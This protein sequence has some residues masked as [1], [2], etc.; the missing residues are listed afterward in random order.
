MGS[1]GDTGL[2]TVPQCLC[3]HAL[4]KFLDELVTLRNKFPVERALMSKADVSDAFRNVRV[5]PDQADNFCYTVGDVIVI[6][7]RLIFGWLGSPGFWAVM[8]AAAEH[9][10]GS[11]A[12]NS[13]R[14]LDEGKEMMA[15][16]KVADRWEEGTPTPIPP[17]AKIRARTAGERL[18]TH[19]SQPCT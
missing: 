5:D 17:D 10:H 15:H 4:P 19:F 3:A 13:T 7:L 14:L 2:D 8:S 9:A 12:L 6:D 11:T 1:N 16:V 18:S